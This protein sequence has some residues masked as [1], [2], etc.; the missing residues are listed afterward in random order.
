MKDFDV[1]KEAE[2]G[3]YPQDFNLTNSQIIEAYLKHGD[4]VQV[5]QNYDTLF[6]LLNGARVKS[7]KENGPAYTIES[8]FTMDNIKANKFSGYELLAD[9]KSEVDIQAFVKELE[10]SPTIPFNEVALQFRKVVNEKRG[11][12][13]KQ[14][15]LSGK[16]PLPKGLKIENGE[17]V[18]TAE[19]NE[20]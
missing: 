5:F 7:F 6:F 13:I 12:A 17:I 20:Q 3:T 16:R 14:E 11:A 8:D 9:W 15:I 1:L 4:V 18:K 19:V 10:E 2:A